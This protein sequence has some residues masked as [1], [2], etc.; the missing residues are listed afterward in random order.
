[1][2]C[3]NSGIFDERGDEMEPTVQRISKLSTQ[4]QAQARIICLWCNEPLRFAPGKGFVH[5]DGH[6][7]KGQCE[8][9]KV[10]IH[11]WVTLR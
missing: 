1:M 7:Y 9:N 8:E 5:Q 10:L 6:T 11:Q 4:V 2:I 3:D